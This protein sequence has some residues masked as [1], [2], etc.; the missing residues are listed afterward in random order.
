MQS[1]GF[2]RAENERPLRRGVDA[3]GVDP[4]A[5]GSRVMTPSVSEMM[6]KLQPAQAADDNSAKDD[7]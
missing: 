6:P 5:L 7:K 2:V 1:I 4:L 3:R